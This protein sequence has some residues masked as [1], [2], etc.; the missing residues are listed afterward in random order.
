MKGYLDLQRRLLSE[1]DRQFNERTG[2]LMIGKA[3]H[4]TLYD[5]REGLP[6]CT[7]KSVPFRIV[8]EE[9]LWFLRGERNVRSLL[10]KNI[11]IWDGNA[12]DLHLRRNNM[13]KTIK[14]HTPEWDNGLKEYIAKLKSDD[15]FAIVEGDLGPIY[16]YQWRNWPKKDG[17]SIDQLKDK[18]IN[19]LRK[20][21]GTRYAILSAWNPED[22]DQMAL[23]PCHM[24]TQFNVFE[25]KFLDLNMFQR[26]CDTFL[27]VPFNIAS[28]GLFGSL[29]ARELGYEAREFYHSYG[30]VHIYAGVNPR[31]QFLM[32]DNN[33]RE[34]RG[35]VR[36]C[37]SP[38]DYLQVRDEYIQKAPPE[39]KGNERKDHIPFILEQLSKI[40]KQLPKLEIISDLPFF[41]LINKPAESVARLNG[42]D[43]EKWDSKAVMAA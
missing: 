36:E 31:S 15:E 39:S 27:G 8:A 19:N 35:S 2:M 22:V 33:F 10:D 43:P 1:G 9:L 21:P 5:L 38:A 42:Y 40:P 24:T 29:V 16:G 23:A 14:K 20:V 30:N 25:N 12:Y 32:D 26:S 4:Q 28:Y 11:H 41:D 17:S 3:G 13:D 37:E 7:T 34:F 18:V 6:M